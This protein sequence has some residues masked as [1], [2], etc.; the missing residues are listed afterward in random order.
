MQQKRSW[1]RSWNLQNTLRLTT[2]K[3]SASAEYLV[4]SM[5]IYS[6]TGGSPNNV[7]SPQ[8]MQFCEN[9]S[10]SGTNTSGS[11]ESD[12]LMCNLLIFAILH[13][14]QY[15]SGFLLQVAICLLLENVA[16]LQVRPLSW[17][18]RR[19]AT[20]RRSWRLHGTPWL[21]MRP[22]KTLLYFRYCFQNIIIV[23]N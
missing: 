8:T 5:T 10:L 12:S 16:G 22:G 15:G 7:V 9:Q 14:C 23:Q 21:Y 4:R 11:S 19:A 3:S 17:M 6:S 1:Q 20:A 2:M 13:F 18:L